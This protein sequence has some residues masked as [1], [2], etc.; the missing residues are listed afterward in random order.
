M[1][2]LCFE[3][4]ME[5]LRLTCDVEEE[6]VNDWIEVHNHWIDL[7]YSLTECYE[8]E[9][10]TSRHLFREF[11]TL[12]WNL[13]WHTTATMSGAYESAAR[14]LRYILEGMCQALYLDQV[15][16]SFS[17][18]EGYEKMKSDRPPRGKKLI[19]DLRLPVDMKKEMC[20]TI[21][22]LHSYAHPSIERLMENMQ[23]PKVVL[24]HNHEWFDNIQELHRK[25][26]DYVLYVMLS[27]FSE[28]GKRFLDKPHVRS[29]LETMSCRNTLH[30]D[31]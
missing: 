27:G 26:C 16:P 23:D 4:P 30:L 22:T 8:W 20:A 29:S 5:V 28:V 25:T 6:A 17:P 11:F 10:L 7:Y 9:Y 14:D 12:L 1:K 18:E 2:G 19:D 15:Y 3:I 13:I 21:D 24:F 31:R